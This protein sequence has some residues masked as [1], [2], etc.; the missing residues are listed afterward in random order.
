MENLLAKHM[1]PG[2]DVEEDFLG[3]LAFNEKMAELGKMATGLVHELNTPLSVI[4]AASQMILR[5]EGVSEFVQEMVERIG[6]EAQ[7][8]SQLTRGV[9]NF[10]REEEEGTAE[11]DPNQVLLEVL[12]FLKYEAQKRSVTV[13]QE[14]DYRIPAIPANANRL[15][16]VF[17]NLTMNALQAMEEG[18]IL[19]VGTSLGD[20]GAVQVRIADT[21]K[22]IEQEAIEKIFEPFYTTK[23][24]GEGTGLGL[25]ITRKIV[26]G[27]HG[28]ITVESAAGKGT[29]FTVSLPLSAS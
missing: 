16:Q 22:G 4:V 9:L 5:E 27:L 11:T 23:E 12:A 19:T 1:T 7:R 24:Q 28:T 2:G 26:E 18:G 6:I 15:K 29:T 10:A 8:L 14:L 13:R 17:I 25:F 21:G 20:E 3:R